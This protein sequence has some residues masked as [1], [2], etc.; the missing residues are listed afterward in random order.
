MILMNEYF[1]LRFEAAGCPHAKAKEFLNVV[2]EPL[3]SLARFPDN[4]LLC[5]IY[6]VPG[7]HCMTGIAAKLIKE[8]EKSFANNKETK[9]GTKFVD[10]FLA[11]NYVNRTEYQGSH[12]FEGNHARKL[13]EIIGRMR[14]EVEFLESKRGSSAATTRRPSLPSQRPTWSFT[15]PTRSRC[16]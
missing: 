7:L 8:I 12:S 5:D 6:N 2:R 10:E 3:L 11:K 15:R 9:E 13:L 14:H 4:T 1:Y 16:L